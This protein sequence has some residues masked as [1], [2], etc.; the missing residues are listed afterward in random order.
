MIVVSFKIYWAM[1]Q[2]S[3]CSAPCFASI[4]L[5]WQEF[6]YGSIP[7]RGIVQVALSHGILCKVRSGDTSCRDKGRGNQLDTLSLTPL[8]VAGCGRLQLEVAH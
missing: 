5:T 8:S 3:T 7:G 4:I 6:I 1:L 2:P